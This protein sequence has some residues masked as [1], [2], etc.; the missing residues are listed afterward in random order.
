MCKIQAK[1]KKSIFL[2]KHTSGLFEQFESL[3]NKIKNIEF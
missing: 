3:K 1:S 2:N